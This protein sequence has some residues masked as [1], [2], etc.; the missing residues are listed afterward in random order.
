VSAGFREG[1]ERYRGEWEKRRSEAAEAA[2]GKKRRWWTWRK[3]G[4][5]ENSGSEKE[6]SSGAEPVDGV[7]GEK[8]DVRGRRTSTVGK[9]PSR[10]ASP[11]RVAGAGERGHRSSTSIVS[12]TSS[13]STPASSRA[14]SPGLDAPPPYHLAEGQ[15]G[16]RV[17]AE[18]FSALLQTMDEDAGAGSIRL[19]MEDDGV[20]GNG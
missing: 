3:E 12:V 2:A 8:G 4:G 14:P 7:G 10:Q 1:Y 17:R 15:A 20:R 6:S 16:G 5:G 13:T 18:S 9:P 19:E 11:Y